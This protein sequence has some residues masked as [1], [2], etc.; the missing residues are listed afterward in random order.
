MLDVRRLWERG[1]F[2]PLQEKIKKCSP[3][4]MGGPSQGVKR[5][6]VVGGNDKKARRGKSRQFRRG[7][8][9]VVKTVAL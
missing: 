7:L 1:F 3:K 8:R 9:K 5:N 6:G 2:D 4:A